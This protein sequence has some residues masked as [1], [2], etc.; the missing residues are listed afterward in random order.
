[1][2]ERELGSNAR[3]EQALLWAADSTT[4]ADITAEFSAE[5]E[6]LKR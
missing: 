5:A 2:A 1:L 4:K 6:M 3:E